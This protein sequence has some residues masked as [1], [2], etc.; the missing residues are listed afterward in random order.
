MN[1]KEIIQAAAQILIDPI[2]RLM[3]EDQHSW[4]DRPCGTCQAISSIAGKSF[5]CYEYQRRRKT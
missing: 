5:G 1:E 2:L 3:Q 4:G